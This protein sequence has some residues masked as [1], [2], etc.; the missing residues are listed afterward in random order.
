VEREEGP[1]E[2]LPDDIPK[3][4]KQLTDE[5]FRAA[6]DLEFEKAAGLRDRIRDLESRKIRYG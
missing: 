5:M 1:E 2:V 4:I 6:R 3:V